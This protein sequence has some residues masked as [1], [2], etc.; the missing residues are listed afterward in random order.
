MYIVIV[1]IAVLLW[2]ASSMHVYQ[3]YYGVSHENQ[4]QNTVY[5]TNIYLH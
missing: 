5:L 2:S 1:S 4:K 3:L